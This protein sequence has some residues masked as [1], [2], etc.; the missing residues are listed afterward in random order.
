MKTVKIAY[1]PEISLF[2]V[3][4]HVLFILSVITYVLGQRNCKTNVVTA[5]LNFLFRILLYAD[6]KDEMTPKGVDRRKL[7]PVTMQYMK[8]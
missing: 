7:Y 5:D 6:D 8:L 2:F 3:L 1:L 4:F